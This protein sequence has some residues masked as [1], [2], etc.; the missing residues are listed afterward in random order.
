MNQARIQIALEL[1]KKCRLSQ[2]F[3]YTKSNFKII[4]DFILNSL[5]DLAHR[6]SWRIQ[7]RL[8]NLLKISAEHRRCPDKS[9]RH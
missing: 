9:D 2:I 6:E 8:K 7:V 4:L 3:E 5:E 1:K